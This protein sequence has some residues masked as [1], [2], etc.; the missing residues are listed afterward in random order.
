MNNM[1]GL[2]KLFYIDADDFVSLEE[3]EDDLYELTLD[4][5]A[6]IHEIHFTED[7]GKISE[8]EEE[9]DNGTIY[10]FETSVRIPGFIASNSDL[11]GALKHKRIMILGMDS[12]ENFILAG[13]PGSY[14]KTGIASTTGEASPDP[15]SK[16]LN[17]TASFAEGVKFIESP[18]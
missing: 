7:T 4:N 13:S 14:F 2:L 5:G 12:N 6:V 3:G 15:N 8:T 17:I 1:G 18:L 9:T 16:R 11:M 10:N